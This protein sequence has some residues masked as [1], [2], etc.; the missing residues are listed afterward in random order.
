MKTNRG[1]LF[2]AVLALA[3]LACNAFVNTVERLVGPAGGPLV[4]TE[5]NGN[6]RVGAGPVITSV[7]NTRTVVQEQGDSLQFIEAFAT[8]QYTAEE[9]SQ[10]GHTYT[11]TLRLERDTTVVWGTNWCTTTPEL[12]TENWDHISLEFSVNGAAIPLQQF[13][14][15][16]VQ[17]GDMY[18][19]HFLTTLSEWPAGETALETRVTFDTEI[20]DGLS[21][22][23]AGTHVYHYTVTVP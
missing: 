22:Y 5:A 3:S 8:E 7:E 21:N 16:E 17:S 18:C 6:L 2:V 23:P 19:R 13:G 14:V 15:L 4:T 12:L 1:I 20:N 11:Y 10:A 9:L